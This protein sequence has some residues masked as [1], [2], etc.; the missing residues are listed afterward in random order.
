MLK[1]EAERADR[2]VV[3]RELVMVKVMPFRGVL[4]ADI[5]HS[6]RRV[7]EILGRGFTTDDRHAVNGDQQRA[8]EQFVLMSAAGMGEDEGK[9]RG[10]S[11]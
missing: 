2:R 7:G 9:H 3:G 5:D 1:H 11:L 10:R 6:D 8:G 4:A